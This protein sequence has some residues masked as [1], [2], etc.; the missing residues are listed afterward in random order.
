MKKLIFILFL[1]SL[2]LYSQTDNKSK[3]YE[4]LRE[5]GI[6]KYTVLFMFMVST[7]LFFLL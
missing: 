4:R 1:F 3:A 2:Y 6:I 7:H 5:L